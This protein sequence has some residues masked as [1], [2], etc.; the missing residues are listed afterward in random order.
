MEKR[1]KLAL[2]TGGAGFILGRG[3]NG[4]VQLI[5]ADV[6]SAPAV[7]EAVQG[8]D[9][10]FHFAAQVAVTTSILDPR[11]DFDI[12][13]AGTLN[14]LEALRALPEPPPLL[15]TSTNKIHG[16]LEDVTL[17][18]GSPRWQPADPQTLRQGIDETRLLDLHSPYGCSKGAA[19][20]YV[21]DYSRIFDLPGVVFRMSCIYGLHQFGTEDRGWVAH[22]LLQALKGQAI[23]LYGDGRQVRDILAWRFAGT[24]RRVLTRPPDDWGG[25]AIRDWI[26]GRGGGVDLQPAAGAGPACGVPRGWRG[27]PRRAEAAA[28]AGLRLVEKPGRLEWMDEP[29]DDVRETGRWLAELAG[30]FRGVVPTAAIRTVSGRGGKEPAVLPAGRESSDQLYVRTSPSTSLDPLPLKETVAPTDTD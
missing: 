4:N 27:R 14:L 2:I 11:L 22:F 29:W 24:S 6:R 8:V 16:S 17:E 5:R 7:R 28:L 12:N 21:L 3:N 9:L 10:V 1:R 20:Q 19:D 30:V 13:L 23:T 26:G 18:S 15:F 25:G